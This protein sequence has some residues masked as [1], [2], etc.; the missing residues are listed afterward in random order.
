MDGWQQVSVMLGVAGIIGGSF[1]TIWS[2]NKKREDE[3]FRRSD[4]AARRDA[5]NQRHM[6]HLQQEILEI[7]RNIVLI[8]QKLTLIMEQ[9]AKRQEELY[10]DTH[11]KLDRITDNQ[12]KVIQA[13]NQ[14]AAVIMRN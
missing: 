1:V 14:V 4:D 9:G 3:N 7:Q 11:H 6:L 8:T 10:R 13:V 5:D 12:E 2:G